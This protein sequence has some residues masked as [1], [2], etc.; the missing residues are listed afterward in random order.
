MVVWYM[1][2]GKEAYS[3]RS[4]WL[5]SMRF[6]ALILSV[7]GQKDVNGRWPLLIVPFQDSGHGHIVVALFT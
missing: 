4:S 5:Y 3:F 2:E 6:L 7:S 1:D